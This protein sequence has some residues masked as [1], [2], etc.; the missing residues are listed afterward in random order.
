MGRP[1]GTRAFGLHCPS[2]PSLHTDHAQT[3]SVNWMKLLGLEQGRPRGRL[4]SPQQPQCW[5]AGAAEDSSPCLDV[6]GVVVMF[7]I[8]VNSHRSQG[9]LVGSRNRVEK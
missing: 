6:P 9:W 3:P 7:L 8:S 5:L 4:L 1:L 2:L